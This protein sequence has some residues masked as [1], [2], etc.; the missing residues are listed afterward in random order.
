MNESIKNIFSFVKEA[1]ELRNKNIYDVN[2][3]PTY[4]DL[5]SFYNKYKSL[6]G[7]ED[8]KN[9][10]IYSEKTI[11]KL[12]YISENNKKQCPSIPKELKEYI[13]LNEDNEIE[14]YDYNRH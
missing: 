14:E 2:N 10:D 5:G 11:L 4:I 9:I 8:Y 13:Y 7:E 1:L 6:I 3:Y 12:K